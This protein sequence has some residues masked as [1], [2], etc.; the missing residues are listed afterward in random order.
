MEYRE[1]PEG[2]KDMPYFIEVTSKAGHKRSI[3]VEKIIYFAEDDAGGTSITTVGP[4]LMVTVKQSY[5][6][7][8]AMVQGPRGDILRK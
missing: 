2:V 4:T 7:V 3:N 1:R 5:D 8:K 6:E